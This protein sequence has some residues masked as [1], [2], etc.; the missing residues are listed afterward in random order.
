[1]ST[2]NRPAASTEPP[3]HQFVLATQT[4]QDDDAASINSRHTLKTLSGYHTYHDDDDDQAQDADP[5]RTLPSNSPS[6]PGLMPADTPLDPVERRRLLL[7][8]ALQLL[9]LFL[10]CLLG[11]GGTLWLALPVIDE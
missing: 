2:F 6:A 4:S 5:W 10:V 9:A 7:R 3:A 11:L 1:M 8:A